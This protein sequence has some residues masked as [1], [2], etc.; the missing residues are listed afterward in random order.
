MSRKTSYDSQKKENREQ[1]IVP[2][3]KFSIEEFF[4]TNLV[5]KGAAVLDLGCG[6]QPFRKLI[7][8]YGYTYYSLD[9]AQ[10]SFGNVDF[11]ASISDPLPSIIKS[12]E[13]SLILCSEVLEHVLDLKAALKN[14]SDILHQDGIVFITC[15]FNY[16]LHEV[17]Y[18]YW[19][20]TPYA[21]EKLLKETDLNVLNIQQLGGFWESLGLLLYS[22]Y[23]LFVRKKSL[24]DRILFKIGVFLFRLV[25]KIVTSSRLRRD[26]IIESEYFVS[27]ALILKKSNGR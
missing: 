12:K 13:F 1:F 9:I 7:E 3:L 10:N 23:P 8:S 14:I 24:V 5:D 26:F 19:R 6:N 27:N 22:S 20:P 15:P 16:P 25:K 18:D 11:I 2:N 21:F 17:P 4:S